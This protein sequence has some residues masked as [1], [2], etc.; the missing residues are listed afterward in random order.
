MFEDSH[1]TDF[2]LLMKSIL[3]SGQEDVPERVWEGISEELDSLARRKKAALWWRR[4]AIGS[5]AAAVVAVGMFLGFNGTHMQ[6]DDSNMIAVVPPV[7]ESDGNITL[8]N[9]EELPAE[10]MEVRSSFVPRSDAEFETAID[11]AAAD[12]VQE[13]QEQ[14]KPKQDNTEKPDRKSVV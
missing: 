8:A 14:D 2:D 1:N 6:Q 7:Q 11:E 3:E 13:K 9:A 4:A 12:A 10:H 5:A